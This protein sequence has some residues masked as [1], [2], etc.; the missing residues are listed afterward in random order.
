MWPASGIST[1]SA[2]GMASA[3]ACISG[4]A[5]GVL[6]RRRGQRRHFDCRQQARSCRAGRPCRAE[7]RRS[8]PATCARRRGGRRRR[9]PAF[10][11]TVRGANS[12]R[13]IISATR[14]DPHSATFSAI[15]SRPARASSVS[16]AARV[17][18]CTSA[19]NAV[20]VLA[21]ELPGDVAA[22]RKA[23]Q[24]DRLADSEVR[25][26]ARPGRRRIVPSK[27]RVRIDVAER[28]L[29]EAAQIGAITRQS[30]GERVDLGSPHRVV[31]REA[32][33]EQDGRAGAAV[34]VGEL[35]GGECGALHETALRTSKVS[36]RRSAETP[37]LIGG[38]IGVVL[39]CDPAS[40]RALS[41]TARAAGA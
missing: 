19:R 14:A 7:R 32:V 10:V 28:R 2:F 41:R 15:L 24:H 23:D 33:D 27:C 35:D 39:L 17:S 3:I 18:H 37:P 38:V 13:P 8:R 9:R 5:D 20:G 4:R 34:D 11:R 40:P 36:D 16:A 6:A 31:E 21:D 22:H 30:L 1:N 29:A 25:R 12:L 26:A